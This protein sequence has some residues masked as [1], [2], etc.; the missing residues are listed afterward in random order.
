MSKQN[1]SR[2]AFIRGT[3]RVTIALPLMQFS[4]KKTKSRGPSDSDPVIAEPSAL[5]GQRRFLTYS[6]SNG[7]D[8]LFWNYDV[9]L[10]PLLPLKNKITVLRGIRN[11]ASEVGLGD[12]HEQGGAT[13]FVGI[14][15]Q[16]N[17]LA[18]GISLDQYVSRAFDQTSPLKSPLV[19]G[20]WRG[21]A[22]G[23]YRSKTW[24][25]RSWREGGVPAEPLLHPQDTFNAIFGY[26]QT[27]QE[28]ASQK[29]VL[30]A[31]LEQYKTMVGE[32]YGL[33]KQ[34][35]VLLSD[36][37]ERVRYIE[38][39]V[40]ALSSA[41]VRK[42]RALAPAIR[43]FKRDETGLLAYG[44]FEEAMNLH[45]ELCALAFECGIVRTASLTFNSAGEEFSNDRV[46]AAEHES[47]HYSEDNGKGQYINSRIFHM[48]RLN[49]L[50]R[51]LDQV[52]EANGKTMLDSTLVIAGTEFGESRRH[53]RSP[54]PLLVAGA[55][56]SFRGGQVIDSQGKSSSNDVY[57]TCLRG[58][59][60]R[61][62]IFG[63]PST[64]SGL[65]SEMLIDAR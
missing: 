3:G 21:F 62:Q 31:V 10:R 17:N 23:I 48:E 22:G 39:K 49:F 35:I 63:T 25:C 36:H 61:D 9:A 56:D 44:D 59:G 24:Y 50:L 19:C 40:Q 14:P 7:C 37:M 54:Q 64:N 38:Q 32:R 15:I 27:P 55:T 4:C 26:D 60:I 57:T 45:I 11:L 30:D 43:E 29:S 16:S 41:N 6:F 5:S 42:F 20:V 28:L 47:S 8:P 34:G 52:K 2:R 13:L 51:R 18:G 1:H 46:G 65:L 33:S 58:L 53:E 12:E